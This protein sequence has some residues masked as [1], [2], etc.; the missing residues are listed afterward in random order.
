M[1]CDKHIEFKLLISLL[2][3]AKGSLSETC[4][5]FPT[6]DFVIHFSSI[7]LLR[8]TFSNNLKGITYSVIFHMFETTFA[9]LKPPFVI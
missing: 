6:I 9:L 2:S 3:F 1:M 4:C 7:K 5:K 8:V